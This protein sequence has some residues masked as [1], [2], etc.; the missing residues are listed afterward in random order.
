MIISAYARGL[1]L[2]CSGT[3]GVVGRGR[4]PVVINFRQVVIRSGFTRT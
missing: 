1:D 2:D 3:R 4:L